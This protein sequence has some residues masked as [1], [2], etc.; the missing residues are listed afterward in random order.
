[1]WWSEL[2]GFIGFF[3]DFFFFG[4]RS[5]AT[6]SL[7]SL[8]DSRAAR[9]AFLSEMAHLFMTL[10]AVNHRLT[11]LPV[12]QLPAIAA[13]LASSI[14]EC[15]ELLSAPQSQK[16][17][18]ADSDHAVQV[19]KLVTRISSL[20]QDRSPEGRWAAVVLVKALVESGQWEILRGSEPFVRGLMGILSVSI[21]VLG[22][23]LRLNC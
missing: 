21:L 10:R 14:T 1:M 22:F 13:S 20:L 4:Q 5:Q 12:Q 2:I 3:I 8:V 9:R 17:G 11:N 7:K 16:A 23:N 6:P 15:G 19:H 18:K